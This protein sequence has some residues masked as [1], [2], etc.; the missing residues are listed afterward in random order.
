MVPVYIFLTVLVFLVF[1]G[2]W[3]IY[4]LRIYNSDANRCNEGVDTWFEYYVNT[5]FY[6]FDSD[7]Y[8]Y[9][10]M[11]EELVGGVGMLVVLTLLLCCGVPLIIVAI[12]RG[13]PSS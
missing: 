2:Y 7:Y 4:G 9:N 12:T 10:L 11:W 1:Q 6:N 13:S 5:R 8:W 3:T